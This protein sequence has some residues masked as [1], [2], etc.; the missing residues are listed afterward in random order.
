MS[1]STT[2]NKIA[3]TLSSATQTLAVPFYFL[4]NADLRVLLTKAA[5]GGVTT[6]ALTTSY[7]ASG[8]GVEAGGSITLTGATVSGITPASGDTVTIKRVPEQNQLVDYVNNDAFPA[9]THERALDKLTMEVQDVQEQV[10]R[11]LRYDETE[12]TDGTMALAS[13][14]GKIPSFNATTG[15]LEWVDK[16]NQVDAAASAAAAAASAAAAAGGAGQWVEKSANFTA[17]NDSYFRVTASATVTNP[18]PAQGKGYFIDV[19]SGTVTLPDATSYAA[20]L[21]I[22]ASYHSGAWQYSTGIGINEGGTGGR[23]AAAA[24][25]AL[26][27]SDDR[28]ANLSG[29]AINLA[30][31][32]AVTYAFYGDSTFAGYAGASPTPIATTQATLRSF[33]NNTAA[34]CVN[35]GVSG[36]GTTDILA[37][38]AAT[39]AADAAP[40]I[41]CNWGIND[42]QGATSPAITATQYEANVRSIISTIRA[43]GK[44]AV[45]V[46]PVPT[47]AF[48][49]GGSNLGNQTKAEGVR[50]FADIARF[51][52]AQ[53]GTPCFDL[54][55]HFEKVYANGENPVLL[56]ADGIHPF[57]QTGYDEMG[58][59]L[60]WCIIAAGGV[61]IDSSRYIP[62]V[63]PSF[64]HYGGSNLVTGSGSRT[65]L[66]RIA[67]KIRILVYV[68][69]PG[70]DLYLLHAIWQSGSS[71]VVIK[72]DTSTVVTLSM[73]STTLGV[74]DFAV[75]AS[76]QI[77]SR[78]RPGVHLIEI[79]PASGD[80]AVYGLRAYPARSDSIFA[81]FTSPA[82]VA[83]TYSFRRAE[84]AGATIAGT[85][86]SGEQSVDTGIPVSWAL[87]TRVV[88]FTGTLPKGAGIILGVRRTSATNAPRGGILVSLDATTGFLKAA[89]GNVSTY[90]AATT[91]GGVDLSLAAHVYRFSITTAGAVT[92]FVD[93][94]S[95]GTFTA[96]I[97]YKGGN[98]GFFIIGTATI[99]CSSLA[100]D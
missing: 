90:A 80:A 73:V 70:Y 86:G 47:L 17:A 94:T 83:P 85:S 25:V 39:V 28:Q 49:S 75:D 50:Q 72:I 6:L 36:Q 48:P 92:C 64:R 77:A 52:C 32:T 41:V 46:T 35:N 10:A 42:Y 11:A 44:I 19:R 53:T 65:N 93:G 5:T 84:L 1:V 76:A 74:S 34:T 40:V 69:A 98:I 24:R 66:C 30:A 54:Y 71:S 20:P 63:D 45:W 96:T 95:I 79:D 33:Y 60:A 8:A 26:S 7:T 18:T 4:A 9:T 23:D 56:N 68:Q 37:A 99:S 43:A 100:I 87:S 14:K 58:R 62:A 59:F 31:G 2:T 21:L 12:T 88:E 89:E 57:V 38:W 61:V 67:N 91:L 78:I 97:P 15:A 16:A 29:Y 27:L 55:T 22:R 3:Y 13:R 82:T 51:V 81:S